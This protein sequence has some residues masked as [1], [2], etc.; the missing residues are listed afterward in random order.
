MSHSTQYLV[1]VPGSDMGRVTRKI[2][3]VLNDKIWNIDSSLTTGGVFY[4]YLASSSGL[5]GVR[6]YRGSDLYVKTQHKFWTQF[7][8]DPRIVVAPDRKQV[9]FW[10]IPSDQDRSDVVCNVVQ[11][12]GGDL[13]LLCEADSGFA[14]EIPIST[15]IDPRI[16]NIT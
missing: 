2:P 13:I 8:S 15:L 12:F 6:F 14:F 7:K 5:I 9:D 3:F 1:F 11:E 4:D 16:L 10:A